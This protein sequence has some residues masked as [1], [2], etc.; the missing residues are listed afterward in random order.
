MM[1]THPV[2]GLIEEFWASRLLNLPT[3]KFDSSFGIDGLAVWTDERLDLIAVNAKVHG[4]GSF[5]KFV[6]ACK[7]HWKEI[8]VWEIW[9]E[10]LPDAL[11]R[12]GF[13][14]T[15]EEFNGDELEGMVWRLSENTHDQKRHRRKNELL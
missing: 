12:Y 6:R 8:H 4:K 1:E 9:N 7:N 11:T 13:L 14:W 2:L 3:R 15:R 5:R 10:F